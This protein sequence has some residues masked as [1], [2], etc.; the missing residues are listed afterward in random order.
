MLRRYGP[1]RILHFADLTN[2][3]PNF[4]VPV[5]MRVESAIN[6]FYLCHKLVD[7]NLEDVTDTS[8]DVDHHKKL[9]ACA[10]CWLSSSQSAHGTHCAQL[11][12]TQTASVRE[13]P[14]SKRNCARS[15]LGRVEEGLQLLSNFGSS[16]KHL[17]DFWLES[18]SW[19]CSLLWKKLSLELLAS[20][21][22]AVSSAVASLLAAT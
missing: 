8:F 13:E 9:W 11:P 21:K 15:K 16:N 10:G 19:L 17:F 2:G 1:Q 18:E 4:L 14:R 12:C 6:D 7:R 3:K 22:V 20:L 5:R